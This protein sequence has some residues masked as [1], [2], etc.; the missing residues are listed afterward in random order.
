MTSSNQTNLDADS[1]SKTGPYFSIT[2]IIE[3]CLSIQVTFSNLL[4]LAVIFSIKKKTFS[5]IIFLLISLVD[6]FVGIISIPGDILLLLDPDYWPLS[7]IVCIIYKTFDYSSSNLSLILLLII[8]VHRYKL[9]K[10]PHRH[11]EDMSKI[12]WTLVGF[13]LSSSYLIWLIIWFL[14]FYTQETRSVCYFSFNIYIYVFFILVTV[15]PFLFVIL[16][17][18]LMIRLFIALKKTKQ[19]QIESSRRKQDRAIY[20]I[21]FITVNLILCWTTFMFLWPIVKVCDSCLFAN[22]FLDYLFQISNVL[23]YLF[24]GINPIILLYFN[25]NFRRVLIEKVFYI[26]RTCRAN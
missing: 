10:D 8:T 20:C 19:T 15:I 18:V 13:V 21:L 24:S 17:N 14:Y 4:V 9:L 23:I 16:M 6:L 7:K 5:N 3:I 12:K 22:T 11:K 26:F 25:R 2:I 1:T